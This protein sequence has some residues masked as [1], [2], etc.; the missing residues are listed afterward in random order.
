[1]LT[2]RSPGWGRR[3]E[4]TLADKVHNDGLLFGCHFTSFPSH[5]SDCSV[6]MNKAATLAKTEK[7]HV[8]NRN[9]PSPHLAWPLKELSLA[10]INNNHL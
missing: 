8:W 3:A 1:M 9:S 2:T 4:E 7:V 5:G 10:L 6:L